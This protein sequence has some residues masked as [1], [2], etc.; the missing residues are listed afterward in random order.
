MFAR[1]KGLLG[2]KLLRKSFA[3][4]ELH[5]C[6]TGK[7]CGSQ[8]RLCGWMRVC[9]SVCEMSVCVRALSGLLELSLSCTLKSP[10]VFLGNSSNS[11]VSYNFGFPRS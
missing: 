11:N 6:G 4:A 5:H 1:N 10:V 9:L 2:L 8:D 7:S 3:G